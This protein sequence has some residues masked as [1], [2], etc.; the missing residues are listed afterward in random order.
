MSTSFLDRF[1]LLVVALGVFLLPVSFL[2]IQ[3]FQ[4]APLKH[5]IFVVITMLALIAWVF[6][7]LRGGAITIPKTRVLLAAAG[8]PLAYLLASFFSSSFRLSFF[9][10]GFE[11]DSFVTILTASVLFALIP[12]LFKN[13]QDLFYLI[14]AFFGSFA[15]LAL[16]LIIRLLGGPGAL[17][18]GV[19]GTPIATPVGGWTEL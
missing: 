15:L 5:T 2:P 19:F 8:V 6:G 1:A 18:F 11:V 10:T 3:G 12:V 14:L 4:A 17:S 13:R 16:F 7:R 9:G